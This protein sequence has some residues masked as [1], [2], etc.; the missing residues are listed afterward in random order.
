MQALA[1]FLPVPPQFRHRFRLQA[2]VPNIAATPPLC[3]TRDLSA[4]LSSSRRGDGT[5]EKNC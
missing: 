2:T 4:F 5:F 1:E 3:R